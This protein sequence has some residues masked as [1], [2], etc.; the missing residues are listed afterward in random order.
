MNGVLALIQSFV[1]GEVLRGSATMFAVRLTGAICAVLMFALL[2]RQM[3]PADF[4]TLVVT[5]N[6]MAFLAANALCGQETLIIRCWGEY[7]GSNR[8]ALAF[9]VLLFSASIGIGVSAL[10]AATTLIVWQFW[11]GALPL[12]FLAASCLYLFSQSV[13]HYTGQWSRVAAGIVIGDGNRDVTWKLIV[14]AAIA[15]ASL[16]GLNFSA[17]A[18]FFAAAAGLLIAV[19][20]QLSQTVPLIPAAVLESKPAYRV[21]EW[22]SRSFKMWLSA[23]LDTTGQYLE[24]ILVALVLGP[25]AAASFFIATRISNLFALVSSSIS[26][27]AT[28]RITP[29]YFSGSK[30]ALQETL[31]SLAILCAVLVGSGLVLVI[32]AGKLLLWIFGAQFVAIYPVLVILVIGASLGA[33]AGPAAQVLLLTGHEGA[34]P[35]IVSAAIAFRFSLIA[36]LGVMFGLYGVAVAWSIGTA[37]LAFGLIVSCRRFVGLDP[38]LLSMFRPMR[39]PGSQ[40]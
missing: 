5:F 19:T 28:S 29:L 3:A 6:A 10:V 20:V 32:V 17:T 15:A 31:R 8:P 27:Y 39:T 40:V 22:I 14:I 13:M 4:D 12:A 7:V 11:D 26:G 34:Y 9:G 36:I 30:D 24:V 38:S 23:L 35:R 18:F 2:A 33:L 21:K 37:L 1:S 16:L 25:S